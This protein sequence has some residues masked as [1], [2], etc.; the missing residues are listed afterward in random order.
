[1][2]W[3]KSAQVV[4]VYHGTMT[5]NIEWS[6][7]GAGQGFSQEG[8][9]IYFTNDINDAMS[10]AVLKPGK[11]TSTIFTVDLNLNKVVK[12]NGKIP[13]KEIKQLLLWSIGINSEKDILK[14]E[15]EKFYESSMSN[16]GEKPYLAFTKSFN[17]IINYSKNPNDAFQQVWIDHY[18]Y[19]S[20]EY[21]QNMIKLGYDGIIVPRTN[22][23]IHYIV[24][25]PSVINTVS[26][27]I[28]GEDKHINV[29]TNEKRENN[30]ELV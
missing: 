18:R 7:L 24:F 21:L 25:N 15:I 1:M 27:Q 4:R 9:G 29:S 17:D 8:P 3:Y 20:I 28:V 6:I 19:K 22:G 30:N 23:V 2:N 26:K 16:W 11:G 10:Y 13:Q 5:D 14:I 12:I